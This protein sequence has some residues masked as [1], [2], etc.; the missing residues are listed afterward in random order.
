MQ[1]G[2]CAI[3][4]GS[5]NAI[6]T[7][8]VKTGIAVRRHSVLVLTTFLFLATDSGL[9][10]RVLRSA[11]VIVSDILSRRVSPAYIHEQAS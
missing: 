8:P 9:H 10:D 2:R 11:C 6:G 7:I 4:S 3:Y 5:T 1:V